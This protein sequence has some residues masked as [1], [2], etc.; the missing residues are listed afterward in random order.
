MADKVITAA[1]APQEETLRDICNENVALANEIRGALDE[2]L[3]T[4]APSDTVEACAPSDIIEQA[5]GAARETRGLLRD[6]K[7]TLVR[8]I[9]NRI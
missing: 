5:L 9:L 4:L 1:Q 7:T 8:S 2:A 6:I 3:G